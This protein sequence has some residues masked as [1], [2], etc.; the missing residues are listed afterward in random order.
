MDFAEK[1]TAAQC[2]AAI[3]AVLLKIEATEISAW[4]RSFHIDDALSNSHI[5]GV[6]V[7]F[8]TNRTNACK[9]TNDS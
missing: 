2:R 5:F 4:A 1:L 8:F 3:V 6:Y 7:R 9:V